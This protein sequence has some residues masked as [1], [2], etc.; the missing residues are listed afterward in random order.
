MVEINYRTEDELWNR[1]LKPHF[2][3]GHWERI[4]T[5]VINCGVPDVHGVVGGIERWVELKIVKG[6][7]VEIRP[8]Q[9]A[10]HSRF[11][12]HGGTSFVL[13]AGKGK[14][15]L[16]SGLYVKE[17]KDSGIKAEV[18]CFISSDWN[19]I[20]Q[21][22]IESPLRSKQCLNLEELPLFSEADLAS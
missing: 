21:K 5:G 4:E 14:L 19:D 13:A 11:W 16:W 2:S 22:I 7:R 15:W 12:R 9:V 20:L 8:T 18:P 1:G 17:L 10:W 6:N 3:K